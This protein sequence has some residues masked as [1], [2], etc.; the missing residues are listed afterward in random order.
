M[1]ITTKE[2]EKMQ[3]NEFKTD[4]AV[5]KPVKSVN[6]HK[7]YT[8]GKNLIGRPKMME[9]LTRVRI[10]LYVSETLDQRIERLLDRNIETKNQ[11]IIRLLE[12]ALENEEK[13]LTNVSS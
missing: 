11:M 9:G 12:Q 7:T 10:S 2:L 4:S 3:N 6:R 8:I 1:A 5:K 13:A